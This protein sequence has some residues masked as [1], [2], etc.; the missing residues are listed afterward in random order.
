[1]QKIFWGWPFFLDL[2]CSYQTTSAPLPKPHNLRKLFWNSKRIFRTEDDSKE[3]FRDKLLA[4]PL[5]EPL[6]EDLKEVKEKLKVF[7]SKVPRKLDYK[8]RQA[9]EPGG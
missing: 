5:K 7:L 8:G 3:G 4:E 9:T 1:M 2:Q 6:Q